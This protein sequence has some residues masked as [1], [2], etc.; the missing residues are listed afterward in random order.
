MKLA[1][2]KKPKVI[3]MPWGKYMG[4]EMHEIPLTYL[5]WCEQN[6]HSLGKWLRDAINFEIQRREGDVTSRGRT[7]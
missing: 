6:T 3:K 7:V 1:F 2:D 5:K 4:C